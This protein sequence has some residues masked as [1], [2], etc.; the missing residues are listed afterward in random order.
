MSHSQPDAQNWISPNQAGRILI[1]TGA[2][3]LPY[4]CFLLV[5][6]LG[7]GIVE[8]GVTVFETVRQLDPHS[9]PTAIDHSAAR[10]ADSVIG[11]SVLGVLF[12]VVAITSGIMM[13]SRTSGAAYGG[14]LYSFLAAI[15]TMNHWSLGWYIV[16]MPYIFLG[17]IITIFSLRELE[18]RHHVPSSDADGIEDAS[19]S[20]FLDS[21]SIATRHQ[22]D[23]GDR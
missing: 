5:M 4:S 8:I 15:L 23:K 20:P 11:I 18:N 14:L 16:S 2:L 12:A 7:S 22:Q 1:I 9:G 3:Q 17:I 13:L 21:D 19:D 6:G 10:F